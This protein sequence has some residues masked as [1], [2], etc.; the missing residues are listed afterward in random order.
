MT[1]QGLLG[2]E[3]KRRRPIECCEGEM[4][5]V[6]LAWVETLLVS[7]ELVCMSCLPSLSCPGA[8]S[9][10]FRTHVVAKLTA[11]V[12]SLFHFRFPL[13]VAVH[14]NSGCCRSAA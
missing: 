14:F 13:R 9:P 12:H 1:L 3:R 2:V 4:D 5:G 7:W 6:L 10:M 8:E 11:L